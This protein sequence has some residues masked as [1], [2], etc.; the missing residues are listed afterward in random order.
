MGVSPECRNAI[1][2]NRVSRMKGRLASSDLS[3]NSRGLFVIA[4]ESANNPE[5][6]FYSVIMDPRDV[7]SAASERVEE[8]HHPHSSARH[9]EAGEFYFRHSCE[10]HVAANEKECRCSTPP[11]FSRQS[12]LPGCDSPKP[13]SFITGVRSTGCRRTIGKFVVSLAS[14]RSS[15]G[16]TIRCARHS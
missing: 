16:A 2:L 3:S 15:P 8:R 7:E 4:H 12:H 6:L 13:R 10:P 11:T 5:L 1:K 9:G 14:E